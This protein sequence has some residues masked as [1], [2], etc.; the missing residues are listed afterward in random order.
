[1]TRIFR[2]PGRAGLSCVLAVSIL[3]A[4][5]TAQAAAA[6][7]RTVDAA[8]GQRLLAL[9]ELEAGQ[10]W[11]GA[12]AGYDALLLRADL[13]AYERATVLSLRGR[14]RYETGDSAGTIADWRAAIALGALAAPDA[15]VLRVNTGQ[16]LMARGDSREGIELTEAA[17]AAGTHLSADLAF[18]LAQAHGQLADY[19]S[20]LTYA[21]QAFD[22]AAPPERRHYTLLLYFYQQLDMG[23]EELG[24][25]EQLVHH[26]PQERAN[27]SGLAA[28]LAREGREEDAFGI[29]R[30]MYLNGML[31]ESPE[32]VRLAQ[33]YSFYEY[34]F[35]GA[36][37][38]ERELN[39]GRVE[40]VA[41]NLSLL[42]DLWRQAREWD[43]ALPVLRRIATSTGAGPDYERLGEALYRS[44]RY[45][46]AEAMFE[47]ALRRGQLVRPGDTWTLIGNARVEQDELLPAIE[48]FE[49]GLAWEYSR[50][51]A[52]GWID[53][54]ERRIAISEAGRRLAQ[55]TTIEE[56][57]LLIERKR[58][59]VPTSQDP[60]FAPDRRRLFDLPGRCAA[61]FDVYGLILPLS[62]RA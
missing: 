50:A 23:A 61:Y 26:W 62:D 53:Y 49:H 20:G 58:R 31:S 59:T 13:S 57:T 3:A 7:E 27:W 37:M 33:Y 43:R 19:A 45:A 16:L 22:L 29:N 1:M 28:I 52:Q 60:G 40:P 38:L 46:D 44:A 6:Q 17:I 14:S 9:I 10:D 18:R 34:P 12:L 24:V 42:A 30:I 36:V 5:A 39:A 4:I 8:L 11:S 48:A 54:I 47:Q 32:L 15:N 56:C 35:R 25:V 51:T 41:R 21:R 2:N 55:V